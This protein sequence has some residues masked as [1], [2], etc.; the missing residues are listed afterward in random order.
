[1]EKLKERDD[2]EY[3]DVER[4]IILKWILRLY[5]GRMWTRFVWLRI[6]VSGRFL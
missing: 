1:M 4:R 5:D 6:G 2:F 3:L